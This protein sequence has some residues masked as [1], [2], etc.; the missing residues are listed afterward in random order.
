M[1]TLSFQDGYYEYSLNKD[2][3]GSN[4]NYLKANIAC[5]ETTTATLTVGEINNGNFE[6]KYLYNFTV[7]EGEHTYMFRVSN[8]YYWYIEETNAIKIESGSQ[9]SDVN[10]QI[11]EGD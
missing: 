5:A 11:L 4:G 10:M 3:L 6:T 7:K 9:L 1:S 2:E 8:D